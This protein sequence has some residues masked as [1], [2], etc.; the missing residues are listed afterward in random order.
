MSENPDYPEDLKLY[1][2]NFSYSANKAIE[3]EML[4]YDENNRFIHPET[5][6]YDNRLNDIKNDIY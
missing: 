1:F 4:A 3:N 2:T 5:I 6:I